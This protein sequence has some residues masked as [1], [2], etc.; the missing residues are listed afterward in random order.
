MSH[1]PVFYGVLQIQLNLSIAKSLITK[2]TVITKCPQGPA[3]F[4]FHPMLINISYNEMFIAS[5]DAGGLK[6]ICLLQ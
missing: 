4:T 3:S 1:P 2:Y 5:Y 6:E